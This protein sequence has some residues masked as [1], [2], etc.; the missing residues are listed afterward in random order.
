[1][2]TA[3]PSHLPCC[4]DF[5]SDSAALG[6]QFFKSSATGLLV[7]KHAWTVPQPTGAVLLL[8]GGGEHC[9][10]Y[11][12]V[13]AFLNSRGLSVYSLDHAGHG[14]SEGDRMHTETFDHYVQDAAQRAQDMA[15]DLPK[16]LPLY[17]LGHS[18]GGLLAI[19]LQAA[20]PGQF[21]AV[22]VT[23]PCIALASGTDDPGTRVALP[24]AAAFVPKA[25]IAGPA[26][27][28]LSHDPAVV[29]QYRRDPLNATSCTLAWVRALLQAQASALH[30]AAPCVTAPVLVLHGAEDGVCDPQGSQALVEVL[31]TKHKEL[32]L[33][34]GGLHE[35]LNDEGF[36]DHLQRIVDWFEGSGSSQT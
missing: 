23:G 15:D 18:V 28:L 8:H 32:Q 29:A 14:R 7:Y 9:G 12:H 34:Q 27:E 16:G 1:M 19:L 21:Q 4:P 5:D 2:H 3:R 26:P 31:A 22:A 17:L 20:C 6:G 11:A 25:R 33:V 36:E 24:L 30:E 10:R 35:I 13:A